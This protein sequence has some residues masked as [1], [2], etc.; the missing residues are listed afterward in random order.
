MAN[1]FLL[2]RKAF[3]MCYCFCALIKTFFCACQMTV[4]SCFLHLFPVPLTGG[5]HITN[6]LLA[7][8]FPW[9]RTV[10]YESSF[11]SI[12]LQLQDVSNVVYFIADSCYF[13]ERTLPSIAS[14]NAV[15]V[16]LQLV[17]MTFN[18]FPLHLDVKQLKCT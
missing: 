15:I 11:F 14:N 10:N 16:Q 4:K 8:F 18:Y 1:W 7:S 2:S 12:D 13:C 6:I 17:I 9:V 5:S 3:V